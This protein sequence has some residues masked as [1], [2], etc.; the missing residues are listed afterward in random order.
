[1]GIVSILEFTTADQYIVHYGKQ[2]LLIDRTDDF[3]NKCFYQ[4]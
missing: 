3:S 4:K 2:R 1:M